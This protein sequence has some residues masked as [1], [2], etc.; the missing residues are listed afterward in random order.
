[1]RNAVGKATQV[2]GL[3]SLLA[4]LWDDRRVSPLT[5]TAIITAL[6]RLRSGQGPGRHEG[7]RAGS[8]VP[9]RAD[10]GQVIPHLVGAQRQEPHAPCRDRSA[11][12]GR[13]APARHVRLR[14]RDHRRR[15]S[16]AAAVGPDPH[17]DKTFCWMYNDGHAERTEIQTGV[18]DGEWIEVTNLQREKESASM[19]LEADQRFGTGDP[20]RPVDPHRG[21]PVEVST[22][23][24]FGT[25]ECRG[26]PRAHVQRKSGTGSS[27][28]RREHL[29]DGLTS[30]PSESF[31]RG[32]PH[33]AE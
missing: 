11:Q 15:V 33:M 25:R 32:T 18:S 2:A 23:S 4:T 13:P 19:P 31:I 14:Q 21:G 29:K 12:P 6:G 10:P 17:G 30:Q 28:G 8:G 20:G 5:R 27:S 9:R 16:A 22:S 26:C 3:K 24:G 1:M 7:V